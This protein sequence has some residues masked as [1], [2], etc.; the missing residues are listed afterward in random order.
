MP[1]PSKNW[2]VAVAALPTICR[3]PLGCGATIST[4][5]VTVFLNGLRS[6]LGVRLALGR[7]FRMVNGVGGFQSNET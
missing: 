7:R 2:M 5:F 3:D 6:V 1:T 4:S